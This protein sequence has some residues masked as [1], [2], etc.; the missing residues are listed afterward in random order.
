MILHNYNLVL[1]FYNFLFYKLAGKN[2][3]LLYNEDKL[4]IFDFIIYHKY[5]S[6]IFYLYKHDFFFFF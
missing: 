6:I 1:L 3:L 5:I 2:E 4:S